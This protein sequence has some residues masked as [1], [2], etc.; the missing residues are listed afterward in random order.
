MKQKPIL[1]NISNWIFDLDNTLYRA[2]ANFFSQIDR[3]ITRYISEYLKIPE[4]NARLYQ[5]EFLRDY[6][7]SLSGMMA[8]HNMDPDEFLEFVHDVD[9]SFLSPQPEL[10]N[11]LKLLKGR[12]FVFTNG[13]RKHALN[14][15][16]HL[17]LNDLFDGSF[18]IEDTNYNPKPNENAYNIFCEHYQVDPKMAI[19]FEDS[20]RNL[21]IPKKMG[22]KTVLVTSDIDWSHEPQCTRPAGNDTI[23]D[24][25]D[26]KTNDIESWLSEHILSK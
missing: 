4:F 11:N 21:I 17:K 15:T 12:K 13:S 25:I 1:S 9:L 23:A 14:V 20:P 8:V 7:T 2:D 16:N 18:G 22:M 19:F 10:R 5:K 3:K 6:G 24:W 26:F